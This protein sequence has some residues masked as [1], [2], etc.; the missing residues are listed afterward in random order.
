[1]TIIVILFALF[2]I[3]LPIGFS[4][5]IA[6]TAHI[7]YGNMPINMVLQRLFSGIDSTALTAVLL[8]SLAG[9]LMMRGG[10]S[11]RLIDFADVLVGHFPSGM[12]MVSV[13]ACMFF[14]ALTGAAVATA[15]AIG[16][17]MIPVMLEKN[18]H[19][20]FTASLLATASS[21][22]PIIPPSIPLLIYGVLASCSVSKL[23]IGGIIPGILM[24]VSLMIVSYF[25]GKKR[26]YI[27]REKHASK[28]E[29]IA[30]GKRAGL[31]LL[32]PVI[33]LGG[34]MGGIFT[35]TESA[36]IA[37]AYATI[38]CI[39]VYRTLS[40]KE[41]AA[42][43]VEAAKV[44]GMVLLVVGFASLFTWVISMQMLPAKLTAFMSDH[45]ASRWMFLLVVN[46][47]LLIA[48]TFIDTISAILIFTPLFLP[49]ANMYG[50]DLVHL[51]VV[52]AVNLSIGMCTPPLGV[53]LFVTSGI[54]KIPLKAMFRD[55]IPQL[56]ALIIVLFIITYI[57][58]SVTALANAF[59]K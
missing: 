4:L 11:D 42:A 27:G 38:I 40:L 51:G 17:I 54:T 57:P 29:I 53:C 15:A 20:G 30:V 32:I 13:L 39:F 58:E 50:V 7:I 43:M 59:V 46:V 21:I 16:G 1:M 28:A 23:F 22:G 10:M 35:A 24:G 6:S 8:F 52:I 41:F 12:A 2:F 18:Y 3:G 14:A 56:V 5:G 44:T 37:V 19:K 49:M 33:I 34:I 47:V 55:L 9:A 36:S 25:V 31:A 26:K 48:G 45:I